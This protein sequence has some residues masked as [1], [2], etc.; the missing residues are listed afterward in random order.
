MYFY[1]L[2]NNN[3]VIQPQK[4]IIQVHN[5]VMAA[6]ENCAAGFGVNGNLSPPPGVKHGILQFGK[7]NWL[8]YIT[9]FA[10]NAFNRCRA[11]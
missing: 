9:A 8:I 2:K 1:S 7:N 11:N 4:E 3:V 6:K 10:V 5:G